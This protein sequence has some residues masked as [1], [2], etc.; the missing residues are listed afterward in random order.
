MKRILLIV[1][2]LI[3]LIVAGGIGYLVALQSAPAVAT[4]NT[5][6]TV[7]FSGKKIL[8]WYDP[9]R[10]D[11]HFKH[12][13]KSPFMDMQL[14]PKYAD[15]GVAERDVVHIDPAT[16]QNL[17]VRSEVVKSGTLS[18]TL[19]VPGTI[20][21]D[22]RLAVVVSAHTDAT[23]EK[24]YVRAPYATVQKG[25]PLAAILAPQWSAAAAEY[26]ALDDAKS[27]DARALHAAA[28]ERLRALG[29]DDATVRGLRSG[30]NAIVL[31]APVD[32]VVS[33]LDAREGQEVGAGMPILRLNGL[34]T[35][36]VDAAIPQA[37]SGGVR[38]GASIVATVSALP[39][40]TFRGDVEA[41]LPE[42]DPVTRTQRARIVLENPRRD[43]A[44]GMFAD[45][46]IDGAAG[47]PH[48]LVPD[49][50][51]I[52][53]GA[54]TRVIEMLS[55]GSFRPMRVKAGRSS[56]GTTEILA[57]LQGGERIVTS[58]QF[59]IDSEAGLSGALE[60]LD[61]KAPARSS[62]DGSHP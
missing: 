31:R 52:A 19:Q 45:L 48:P 2:A 57:G 36:W 58:G 4:D 16:L 26:F 43:L 55:N 50:A 30:G 7:Q 39:G 23:L 29:M 3:A 54:D 10:P 37:Q 34:D 1:G 35:V 27:A 33:E 60:R 15:E 6:A 42:V 47:A 14:L 11:E 51:I 46:R 24:L 32:G 20:A 40:E 12:S 13:G 53:D 41:L 22:Q 5:A 49:E 21:W 62:D 17:G 56:G 18:G 38:A 44:P 61:A 8:Y 59:L 28:R 9:M 25:Q